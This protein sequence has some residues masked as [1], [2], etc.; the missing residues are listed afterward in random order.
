MPFS[1]GNRS[2]TVSIV[3]IVASLVV[4][5]IGVQMLLAGQDDRARDAAKASQ[6]AADRAYADCLTNFAA[7]LVDTLQAGR[8]ATV[9]LNQARDRKDRAL[10]RLI[11]IS[12][13]AQTTGAKTEA[14]L[15]PKLVRAY[16]RT[17][18]ERVAA[19]HAYNRASRHYVETRKENPL[20][21][22]KVVCSR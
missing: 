6:D 16:E 8:E 14:D 2:L 21:S 5:G 22:P 1:R 7:D 15:P 4:V 11:V 12:A 20:V 10:D 18:L 19:Q 9:R 13:K 3:V 17:L